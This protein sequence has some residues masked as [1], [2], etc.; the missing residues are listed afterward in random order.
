C[1][2]RVDCRCSRG[3][4]RMIST[5]AQP[6]R[7]LIGAGARHKAGALVAEVGGRRPLVVTDSFLAGNGAADELVQTFADAGLSAAV[8]S[9]TVPD[10]TTDSLAAGLAAVTAHDADVLVGFGGGSPIDTA[11]ALALLAVSGG[12]MAEYKAPRSNDR[13]ALPIV[14]VPTTAGTGS[15]VTQFTVITDS[16]TDEKMLG[17]GPAFLP[18]AAIVDYELTLTMPARLTA[19]TGIDALTHA[20][21]AYVSRKANRFSDG[22]SLT[23]IRTIGSALRRVYA[24][25]SDRQA[26]EAMMLAATQAGI[27]F[28]N[29]SV[30]LVHG[31]AAPSARTSTWRTAWRTPC[32]CPR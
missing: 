4:G 11:K 17:I 22:M 27:A 12:A 23:A 6:S 8:W 25:G 7:I 30:A 18:A 31:M 15:E 24:D 10:P 20:I 2:C 5:V 19:D 9:G 16:R 21:E 28:S 1:S 13:P 26:R 32:S 14:A 3:D 29:S